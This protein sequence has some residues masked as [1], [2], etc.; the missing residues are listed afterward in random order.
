MGY[1]ENLD[2][3][4]SEC[5]VFIKSRT[6]VDIFSGRE[7]S[8]RRRA[9]F[10]VHFDELKMPSSRGTCVYVGVGSVVELCDEKACAGIVNARCVVG[11]MKMDMHFSM[12]V[13]VCV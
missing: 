5:V 11:Q 9:Y 8:F 12:W 3:R 13:C 6:T 2:Q 10:P 4:C 1:I 7:K